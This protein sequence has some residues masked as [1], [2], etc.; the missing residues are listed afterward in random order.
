MKTRILLLLIAIVALQ[1]P[2]CL[3]VDEDPNPDDPAAKFLGEWKVDESCTRGN[4]TVT[5]TA[6]PG[7]SSQVLLE[8][9]GN[10][11]PGYD[12]AVGIVTTNSI[13]VS[14]QTIGEG[15]T[16][17]GKGTYQSDGTISWDYTL[18]IQPNELSCTAIYSL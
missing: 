18:I 16:V 13:N 7:N 8:N 10:P 14:S 3:P 15:W 2:A 1:M 12:Q 17:S 4:Y 5:I 9:F 11:G 6:D